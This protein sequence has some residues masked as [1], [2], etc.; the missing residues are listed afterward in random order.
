[1]Q[2]HRAA[3]VKLASGDYVES[4]VFGIA[5]RIQDYDPNLRLKYLPPEQASLTDAPYA[6][7]ELCRDGVER[8]VFTIWELDNRVLE[9]LYAADNAKHDVLL[10]LDKHNNSLRSDLNRRYEDKRLAHKDLTSSILKSPKHKYSF[11]ND[12]GELITVDDSA[13]YKKDG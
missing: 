13:P 6:L 12:K 11:K 1:M 9:R 3:F 7:F 10:Q 2:D 5:K 4:D 8:L